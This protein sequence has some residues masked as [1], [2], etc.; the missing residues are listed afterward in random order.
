MFMV[1]DAFLDCEAN[2]S[3]EPGVRRD[4]VRPGL[5]ATNRSQ[6]LFKDLGSKHFFRSVGC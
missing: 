2:G 3:L 6:K 1:E 5:D 4:L